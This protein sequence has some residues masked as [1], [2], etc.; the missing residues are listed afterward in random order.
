VRPIWAVA[1]HEEVIHF[2]VISVFK[3]LTV[4]SVDLWIILNNATYNFNKAIKINW[5]LL[6][7]LKRQLG[8]V[9]WQEIHPN[10]GTSICI[11]LFLGNK[12]TTDRHTNNLIPQCRISCFTETPLL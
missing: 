8:E 3:I 6:N 4:I 7:L 2:I 12:L 5:K 10:K 9:R 1:P 11:L